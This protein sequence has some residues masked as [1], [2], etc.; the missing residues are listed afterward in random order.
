MHVPDNRTLLFN[1]LQDYARESAFIFVGY[2]LDD[3]H[4][5]DLIYNIQSNRR[6]RWYIV[7]PDAEDYDI[8]FWA[9]KNVEV[10]KLRFGEFMQALDTAVPPLW[11]ALPAVTDVADF[12]VR[13]F[14]ITN[15]QESAL[16]R[17]SLT[18]DLTFV[19]TG[20]RYEDQR[21]FMAMRPLGLGRVAPGEARG[22]GDRF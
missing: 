15:T 22:K 13:R 1:R 17:V 14:F 3:P 12:P 18:T 9:T 20:M 16:L 7:T 10:L 4:I 2:R 11:R 21:C 8:A 5:R 6:P 19:H